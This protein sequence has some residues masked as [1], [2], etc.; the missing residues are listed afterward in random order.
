MALV[1]QTL[2]GHG[3]G[4]AVL[5]LC[6]GSGIRAGYRTSGGG[7]VL[8][9]FPTYLIALGQSGQGIRH[10]HLAA[11]IAL[12]AHPL[13]DLATRQAVALPDNLK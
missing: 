10:R 13:Q 3:G 9:V 8:P 6:A 12:K 1:K 11:L 5:S 4:P 2:P 7:P